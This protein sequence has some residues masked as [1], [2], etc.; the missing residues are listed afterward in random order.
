MSDLSWEQTIW[1][2]CSECKDDF[3]VKASI[4]EA[5]LMWQDEAGDPLV[6]ASCSGVYEIYK[7]GDGPVPQEK[8]TEVEG[9]N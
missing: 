8:D 4:A 2:T 7:P 9:D 5:M 1:L 6:C 3:E